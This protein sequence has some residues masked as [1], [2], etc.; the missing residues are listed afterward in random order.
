MKLLFLLGI[1]LFVTSTANSQHDQVTDLM[2]SL[3]RV[4]GVKS[5]KHNLQS[6]NAISDTTYWIENRIY[7]RRGNKIESI[8]PLSYD[9]FNRQVTQ[10]DSLNR[11]ISYKKYDPIDTS[12][13]I[14]ETKWVYI[15]SNHSRQE[16]YYERILQSYTDYTFAENGDTLWFITDEKYT[17]SD[18]RTYQKTRHRLV[19]DSLKITE[20]I[21]YDDELKLS[22]VDV[23]Y[24]V[25]RDI[26]TG[27]LIAEGSYLI[28]DE[29]WDFLYESRDK[30]RDYYNHPE[31]YLQMQLDGAFAYEYGED[32]FTYQIYNYENQLLQD[33]YGISKTTFSYNEQGQLTEVISWGPKEGEDSE[34]YGIIKRFISTYEYNENG[35]P[36]KITNQNILKKRTRIDHF[37]YE[38]W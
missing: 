23:Y 11:E 18:Y 19:G 21:G 6:I 38:Y 8:A 1:A 26:D 10:Y 4:E 7:D 13:Y 29:E 35:L 32:P 15:D 33:G 27:Y 20:H 28:K 3:I 5:L 17:D 25:K 22:G 34:M 37:D 30:M 12:L 31:K 16:K 14:S 9:K 36:I 24:K 2:D